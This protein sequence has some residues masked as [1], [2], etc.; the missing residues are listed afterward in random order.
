MVGLLRGIPYPSVVLQLDLFAS[1][2]LLKLNKLPVLI[3]GYP[4]QLP[5]THMVW[6]CNATDI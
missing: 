5:D 3:S 4:A 1:G 6:S 2:E